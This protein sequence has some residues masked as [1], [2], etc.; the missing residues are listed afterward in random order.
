VS[1]DIGIREQT[2][3]QRSL[4]GFC[5]SIPGCQKNSKFLMKMV[6]ML[7]DTMQHAL[8]LRNTAKQAVQ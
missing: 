7:A 6:E 8:E 5:L 3:T 1:N 2:Y 4:I